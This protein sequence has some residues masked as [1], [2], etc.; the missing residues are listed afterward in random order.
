[1]R[2]LARCS[3]QVHWLPLAP[4]T[5]CASKLWWPCPLQSR[6]TKFLPLREAVG[7][8]SSEQR[9]RWQHLSLPSPGK[10]AG[11]NLIFHKHPLL[12]THPV[13][14][15]A[16][17]N[18]NLG[19]SAL[20]GPP[21]GRVNYGWSCMEPQPGCSKLLRRRR[22][23][24]ATPGAVEALVPMRRLAPLGRQPMQAVPRAAA[25]QRRLRLSGVAERGGLRCRV[26]ELA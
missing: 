22:C 20:H 15:E 7:G 5:A 23:A 24:H 8:L 1:M 18:V 11:G 25:A 21:A 2:C 13:T 16:T 19:E 17:M 10:T 9:A 12:C 3:G 4:V 6:G 14:G 26:S